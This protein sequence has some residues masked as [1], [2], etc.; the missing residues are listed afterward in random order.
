MQMMDRGSFDLR[1]PSCTIDTT[2]LHP[3]VSN[4]TVSMSRSL[5]S[6]R[7]VWVSFF[8]AGKL[9]SANNT[10]LQRWEN[11]FHLTEANAFHIPK[12]EQRGGYQLPSTYVLSTDDYD[13]SAQFSIGNKQL[14]NYP[15]TT[16]RER[17]ESTLRALGVHASSHISTSLRAAEYRHGSNF[18]IGWNFEKS[19]MFATYT[20]L[21]THEGDQVQVRFERIVHDQHSGANVAH[22]MTNDAVIKIRTSGVDIVY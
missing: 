15:M 1:I 2:M 18:M 7:T 16:P 17:H 5:A 20:G 12:A 14:P 3:G 21:P 13:F 11:S 19:L 22:A 8:V 6:V 9:A 10:D 4:S